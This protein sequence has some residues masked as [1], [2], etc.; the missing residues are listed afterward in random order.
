[1]GVFLLTDRVVEVDET[2]EIASL[3]IQTL[4]IPISANFQPD[5]LVTIPGMGETWRVQLP[6]EEW[7]RNESARFLLIAGIYTGEKFYEEFNLER[8]TK[9]PYDLRKTDGVFHQPSALHT[10][11]QMQWII[12]QAIN[13]GIGSLLF[14]AP[15]YH[16][17][18]AYL[19]LLRT[20]LKAK[21]QLVVVPKPL[22]VPPNI[23]IP[24]T[25][26]PMRTMIPGEIQRI[27]EYQKKGYVAT[28]AELND[29]LDN[30]LYTAL[31]F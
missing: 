16:I 15:P 30:F 23:I 22:P 25:E 31:G 7:E 21:V 20:M 13:L 6:I 26:V 24:E 8:L 1:M 17:V 18:R 11:D 3:V 2:S 27:I 5:A 28:L 12:G 29:Y 9:P 19:T 4:T 10:A 14:F